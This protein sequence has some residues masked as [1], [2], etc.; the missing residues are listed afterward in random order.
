[1]KARRQ[2][3]MARRTN[4]QPNT[5]EKQ[6]RQRG[7]RAR[8]VLDVKKGYKVTR[9][10][11]HAL[12]RPVDVK[13]AKRTVAGYKRE[14]QEYKRRGGTQGF[15]RW[16]TKQGY[17]KRDKTCCIVGC[18]WGS[19]RARRVE[20]GSNGKNDVREGRVSGPSSRVQPSWD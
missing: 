7:G 8:F 6:R 15:S 13:E 10:L 1:M 16:A 18:K 11:I 5:R 3:T 14:Y 4:C 2:A 12:K 20:K 17:A 9:D 19:E